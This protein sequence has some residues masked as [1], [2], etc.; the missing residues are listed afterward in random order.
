MSVDVAARLR[1][2]LCHLVIETHAAT[3]L[4]TFGVRYRKTRTNRLCDAARLAEG[5]LIVS[6]LSSPDGPGPTALH[7][8]LV[9]ALLDEGALIQLDTGRVVPWAERDRAWV[10]SLPVRGDIREGK[11]LRSR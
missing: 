7:A 9:V 10:E 3:W 6:T 11:D 5:C 1:S 2:R 4:N 8:S